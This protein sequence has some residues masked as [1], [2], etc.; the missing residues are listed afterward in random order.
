MVK[1]FRPIGGRPKRAGFSVGQDWDVVPEDRIGG[2]G[3][4]SSLLARIMH[5]PGWGVKE[6]RRAWAAARRFLST[7]RTVAW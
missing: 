4:L 2:G 5:N 6:A 7:F 1:R 3:D